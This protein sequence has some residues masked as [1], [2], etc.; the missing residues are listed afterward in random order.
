MSLR[1][2]CIDWLRAVLLL[3]ALLC[4]SGAQAQTIEK[5]LMP[6]E[7]IEGHAKYE[8]DCKQCHLRFDK[9]AQNKL[10]LDCHKDVAADI[11]GKLRLHGKLDDTN[12][13]ADKSKWIASQG[14]GVA[15]GLRTMSFR[16]ATKPVKANAAIGYGGVVGLFLEGENL[17]G[18]LSWFD[19]AAE[20]RPGSFNVLAKEKRHY[21]RDFIIAKDIAGISDAVAILGSREPGR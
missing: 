6:G 20:V 12:C 18:L 5:V 4:V 16:D 8:Q 3:L 9:G 19:P 14:D 11:R 21:V 2:T 1:S 17:Q 7:V 13:L 15:Y 10:C